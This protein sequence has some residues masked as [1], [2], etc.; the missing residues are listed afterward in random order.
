MA[1]THCGSEELVSLPTENSRAAEIC[2]LWYDD[3]RDYIFRAAFWPSVK[4]NARLAVLGERDETVDWTAADPDPPWR[5]AYGVPTDFI[6]PRFLTNYDRFELSTTFSAVKCIVTNTEEAILVYTR[7]IDIPNVWDQALKMAII[8]A[9]AA[10]ITMPLTGK[11]DR[12]RINVEAANSYI[13]GARVMAANTNEN[14]FDSLPDW[15]TARGTVDTSSRIR[16]IYPYG[17]SISF[18]ELASVG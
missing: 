17:P 9:L 8:H 15:I 7:R 10:Q 16:F 12:Y 2:N 14:Q 4:G 13:D 5:F 1:L 3:V 6:A 18:A 11:T